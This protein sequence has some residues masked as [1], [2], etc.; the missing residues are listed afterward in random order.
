M[1]ANSWGRQGGLYDRGSKRK[2]H[3]ERHTF[4]AFQTRLLDIAAQPWG[5]YTKDGRAIDTGLP[6][7]CPDLI[8]I[9]DGEAV[10]LEIKKPRGKVLPSQELFLSQAQDRYKCR[11]GVARCVED[12]LKICGIS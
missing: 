4:G 9:K 6:D 7:G 12:A 1:L 8:A 11:A 10:F 3:S 5:F 2:R